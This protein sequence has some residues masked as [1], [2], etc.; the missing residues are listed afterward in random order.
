MEG[1]WI[2]QGEK[3]RRKRKKREELEGGEEEEEGMIKN[4]MITQSL[5]QSQ[6]K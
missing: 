2:E 3:K 1:T 4:V 6:G 5:V